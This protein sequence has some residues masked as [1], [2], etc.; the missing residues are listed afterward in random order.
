MRHAD[1][2]STSGFLKG[3]ILNI[4]WGFKRGY[5]DSLEAF[6]CVRPDGESGWEPYDVK[7]RTVAWRVHGYL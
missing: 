5:P 2:A 7:R 6:N 4:F 3:I 1:Q